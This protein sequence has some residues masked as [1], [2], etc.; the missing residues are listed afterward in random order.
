MNLSKFCPLGVAVVAKNPFN[1]DSVYSNELRRKSLQ[2]HYHHKQQK[3]GI[4]T[5]VISLE[6]GIPATTSFRIV[7]N[8][9]AY[10]YFALVKGINKV[11]VQ[12]RKKKCYRKKEK[13]F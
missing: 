10:N 3:M 4:K 11:S 12:T 13:G 6:D 2:L 7:K 5:D 1:E 8:C 9:C